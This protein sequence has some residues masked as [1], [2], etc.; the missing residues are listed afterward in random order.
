MQRNSPSPFR[1]TFSGLCRFV[2]FLML[3]PF[4]TAMGHPADLAFPHHPLADHDVGCGCQVVYECDGDLNGY[5]IGEASHPGPGET[6]TIGSTNPSGLRGKEL[7][8]IDHGCGIWHYAESQ[9][10]SV[11]QAT[12]AKSLKY[13]ASQVGRQVRVQQLLHFVPDLP[14]R[15]PGPESHVPVTFPPRS[16]KSIGRRIT[17]IPAECW[18]HNTSLVSTLSRL[19]AYMDFLE[20][21]PGRVQQP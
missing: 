9:L 20:G 21:L 5:R 19:W 17:G 7:L 8:A 6:L 12:A 14:G 4:W 3:L 2:F 1:S 16:F 13:H 18:R 11:T 15:V 10:S